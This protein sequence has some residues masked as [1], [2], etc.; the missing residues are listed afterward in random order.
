MHGYRRLAVLC[1][2][3]LALAAGC[4]VGEATFD[5]VEYDHGN[6]TVT[7]STATPI[8]HADLQVTIASLDGLSQREVFAEARYVDLAAGANRFTYALDLPDGPY[9][10]YLHLFDGQQRRGAVIRELDVSGAYG[11]A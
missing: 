6:L 4:T 1:L 7:V 8:V 9:R 11:H 2:A 10:C 5:P 3:V